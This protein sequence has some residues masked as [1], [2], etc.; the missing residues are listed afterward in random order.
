MQVQ[1]N[2]A[3]VNAN[4]TVQ[5]DVSFNGLGIK[6]IPTPGYN[7]YV[8]RVSKK[9]SSILNQDYST[10]KKILSGKSDDRIRFF[11][12]IA[13]TY[14]VEKFN[15]HDFSK[16]GDKVIK[17]FEFIKNP[18]DYHSYILKEV[19]GSFEQIRNIFS[20]TDSKKSL[21]FVKSYNE[22][23]SLSH[24]IDML[25]N[26]LSSKN[27]KEYISNFDK[28]KYYFMDNVGNK[29][30]I[31]ELD[32]LVSEKKYNKNLYIVKHTI[33]NLFTGFD[34]KLN[35][36]LN[37][38]T[39][40]ENYSKEGNSV[41]NRFM[42]SYIRYN[43][44][45]TEGCY[46]DVMD[47][48]KTTNKKNVNFRK[49]V[50]KYFKHSAE[51]EEQNAIDTKEI[52]AIKDF[53]LMADKDKHIKNFYKK[54]AQAQLDIYSAK[55]IVD[56][57]KVVPAKKLDI[58]FDN[59]TQIIEYTKGEK[60]YKALLTEMENPFFSKKA[61]ENLRQEG[62]NP[63]DDSD[64]LTDASKYIKNRINLFRYNLSKQKEN[65]IIP[66]IPETMKETLKTAVVEP[67][68]K[69]TVQTP[70]IPINKSLATI[71][72]PIILKSTIDKLKSP[73]HSNRK[74]YNLDRIITPAKPLTINPDFSFNTIAP[75]KML[76]TVTRPM[77]I[78]DFLP[79]E[80]PKPVEFKKSFKE[81]RQA[82]KLQVISDVNQIISKKLGV[83]TLE[84]QKP[85]YAK[86]A[87]K[88]RLRLLPEIFDSIR[89]S[90]QAQRQAGVKN[91]NISNKD[92][93]KLY[94]R[95]NGHNRKLV[96]YM[97]L[98]TKSKTDDTRLFTIKD[99]MSLLD[100][101]EKVVLKKKA[102]DKTYKPRQYYNEIFDNY[103]QQY[104]KVTRRKKVTKK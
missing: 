65:D 41:L 27:K 3:I 82:R 6:L 70:I 53:L 61:I 62:F 11:K 74:L 58:F 96:R 44:H 24:D 43:S 31:S 92:A 32:K 54:F 84:V 73:L 15:S 22:E 19:K 2:Y 66:E 51:P 59:F 47:I 104:G 28:Y 77:T 20:L 46:S 29:D 69:E 10:I 9:Y 81:L 7:S 99:I 93:I 78:A 97:L 36:V 79:S 39:L 8:K 40:L 88:M 98:K 48:Y 91:P 14:W 75:N 90:R 42:N 101:S 16:D 38:K 55:E 12:D 30:A 68:K 100:E 25:I 63:H 83:K 1:N 102:Q 67:P 89:L 86:Q 64:A 85:D 26:I 52:K 95:I 87:T 5:S 49:A 50:L 13:D 57:L 35:D 18:N 80:T 56:I 23:L 72:A 21:K 71:Q 94:N 45:L 76:A 37:E 4:K 17:L 103:V 34:M 60:R 33:K